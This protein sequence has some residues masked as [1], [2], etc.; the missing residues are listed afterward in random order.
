MTTNDYA[1]RV[2]AGVLGKIIGVYLGRPFEGWSHEEILER[3]GGIEYYVNNRPGMPP[4]IVTDDDI[5]G[6]FT[7]PR[8]LEDYHQVTAERIGRIWLNYIIENRTILWWGGRG[9]STEHTA[10]LRLRE[11]LHAPASGSAELN[12]SVVAE[13]IGAQIFI[14]GWAMASPGDP[15]RAVALATAAARVSHD[16]EAVHAARVLAAMEAAAFVEPRIDRLLDIGTGYVPADS[17]IA[18]MIGDL[19]EWHAGTS[20]GTGGAGRRGGDWHAAFGRIRERWGYDRF[21][22]DVP[23]VPNHAVIILGLLYGAGDFSESLRIVGTAGWDTD[24]NAGNLGCL[25]GIRNG[26]AAFDGGRDWRGPVADRL[27]LPSADPGNAVSDA[28]REALRIV[29][30][31]NRLDGA[32]PWAPKGGVR[33]S[34]AFPG[35]VQGFTPGEAETAVENVAVGDD[36]VENVAVG[37]GRALQVTFRGAG[38]VTTPTFKLPDQLEM[39]GYEFVASPSIYPGQ[40]ITAEISLV[41]EAARSEAAPSAA[42]SS[43]AAPKASPAARP[44]VPSAAHPATQADDGTVEAQLVL[45]VYTAQGGLHEVRLGEPER[46]SGVPRSFSRRVPDTGGYPIATVGL[47]FRAASAGGA[48]AVLLHSLDWSGEPDVTFTRPPAVDDTPDGSGPRTWRHA[49]ANG[50]DQWDDVWD[51]PFRLA[52]NRGRGLLIQGTRDWRNY[53]AEATLRIDLADAAGIAVRVQGMERYYA[54][55][56]T[57]QGTVRLIRRLE[58]DTVLREIPYPWEPDR[59]Y[60]LRLAAEG[61]TIRASVDGVVLPE[62]VEEAS[63]AHGG[64]SRDGAAADGAVDSAADG[65]A[66]L[67]SGAIAYVLERGTLAS[68]AMRVVP[69]T[70]GADRSGSRKAT[71]NGA[72]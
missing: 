9:I 6:T 15:D 60:T 25:L 33:F 40:T 42:A 14:D 19:R 69:I 32:P 51:V 29:N 68:A 18:R 56:I 16:G 54:L 72:R 13:Q 39:P 45:G 11:G 66:P 71:S 23:V 59:P 30:H 43:A 52:Q 35:S 24:C 34:F 26:L 64:G 44:V 27:L 70:P 28:V 50:V 63:A 21:P 61:A 67:N 4:L 22:G 53:A 3:L 48:A 38:S 12:G 20:G 36:V 58:G 49:W 10:Y 1:E 17:A 46:L 57:S 65:A 37:G 62:W 47:R 55:L 8:A 5:S 31:K 2:Y 7:F 41:I